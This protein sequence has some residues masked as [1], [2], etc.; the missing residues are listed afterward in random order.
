MMSG[1]DVLMMPA[2]PRVEVFTGTARRRR[3]SLDQKTQII[4]YSYATSVGDAS[5]RYGVYKSHL[6][7]WRR[8]TRADPPSVEFARVEVEPSDRTGNSVGPGVIEIALGAGV[9][10]LGPGADPGL[11]TAV[12]MALRGRGR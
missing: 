1:D 3:W 2:S 9:V 4:E 11:A 7:N 5:A 12:I 6:F 10:R 8:E